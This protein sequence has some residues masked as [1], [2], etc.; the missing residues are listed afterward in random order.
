MAELLSLVT[1]HFVVGMLAFIATWFAAF[2]FCGLNVKDDN[3]MWPLRA[4]CY[5]MPIRYG[6]K[7]IAYAEFAGTVFEGAVEC[8]YSI[9][10]MCYPGGFYCPEVG[11]CFGIT[12]EQILESLHTNLDLY[13]S[14]DEIVESI[15]FLVLYCSVMKALYVVIFLWI[16]R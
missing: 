6:V 5:L 11:P 8:T 12:G 2:L 16:C 9:D 15:L 4:L 10:H 14:N 13:S 3:V 7:S 1:P